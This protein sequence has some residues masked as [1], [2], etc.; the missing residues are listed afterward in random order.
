M[1][2]PL[3][4]SATI[5]TGIWW[6]ALTFDYIKVSEH[7]HLYNPVGLASR[8]T[9]NLA[10]DLGAAAAAGSALWIALYA[11]RRKTKTQIEGKSHRGFSTTLGII[12]P[13]L[14]EPPRIRK[15]AP[16]FAPDDPLAQWLPRYRKYPEH[17]ALV[18]AIIEVMAAHDT[19]AAPVSGWHADLSLFEH[20]CNVCRY[21]VTHAA[22]YSY[23]PH[24]NKQG[25]ISHPLH[26]PMYRFDR[27]DPLIALVA[28][29]HD[30]GKIETYIRHDDSSV[31]ERRDDH[32]RLGSFMLARL[33][34]AWE[35]PAEDRRDLLAAVAYYHH[36]QWLPNSASDRSRALMEFLREADAKVSRDEGRDVLV[37]SDQD[38]TA[39]VDPMFEAF[40]DLLATPGRINGR[41]AGLR[42]GYKHADK[43]YLAEEPLRNALAERLGLSRVQCNKQLA[44]RR[45]AVTVHLMEA[46]DNRGLLFKNHNGQSF[47]KQRAYWNVTFTL[48]NAKDASKSKRIAQRHVLIVKLDGQLR[49]LT[50]SL[51]DS[52]GI[53]ESI[54]P[55]WGVRAAMGK[56]LARATPDAAPGEYGGRIVPSQ[57]GTTKAWHEHLQGEVKHT[58]GRAKKAQEDTPEDV[59]RGA[60]TQDTRPPQALEQEQ[61]GRE[62][63]VL[64]P[65]DIKKTFFKLSRALNQKTV[66]T[67][68]V[69]SDQPGYDRYGIYLDEQAERAIGHQD[70]T[71][72][73][74]HGRSGVPLDPS[75]EVRESTQE[76]G[77]YVVILTV[78]ANRPTNV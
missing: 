1:R 12:P 5:V 54:E 34:E 15:A 41:N 69:R 64:S 78:E 35:L 28:M 51:P 75:M 22:D 46:L 70:Y 53:P 26:D 40:A 2:N 19:P 36:P 18:R 16:Q 27:A 9:G 68:Q 42:I 71:A 31:T 55:Y 44:D 14:G 77:T 52:L 57:Q 43:L 30:I 3:V 23:E 33:P 59:L 25:Q 8:V 73:L 76:Q 10:L 13:G 49:Y 11:A 62:N 47:T 29:A 24:V 45:Y 38:E 6:G 20:S 60:A 72:L 50:K 58:H 65:A 48:V 74:I 32:D 67:Q 7:R 56:D 21:M 61:P 4:Q 63:V 37:P 39:A 17:D 66:R